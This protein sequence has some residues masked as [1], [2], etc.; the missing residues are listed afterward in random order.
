MRPEAMRRLVQV[1]ATAVALTA[2]AAPTASA[3]D[4]WTQSGRSL[5]SIN[6]WQGITFDAVARTFNFDGPAVGLWRTSATLKRL[7]GR[8]G[9]ANRG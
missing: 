5:T 7:A 4:L 8:A 3:A 9:R 6:Y 2:V 1:V